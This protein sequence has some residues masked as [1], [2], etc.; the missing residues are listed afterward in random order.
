MHELE[1]KYMHYKTRTKFKEELDKLKTW[2]L[3]NGEEDNNYN[4]PSQ[5][6]T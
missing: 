4:S 5:I 6:N 2:D 1:S 3:D